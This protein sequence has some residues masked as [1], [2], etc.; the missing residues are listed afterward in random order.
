[1]SLRTRLITLLSSVLIVAFVSTSM[2]SYLVSKQRYR[3]GALDETLPLISNNILSE[4]QR[5]LMMPIHVSSL[6][7]NDTFLKDWVL[8]GEED[9]E[10]VTKY[11]KE[12]KSKYGFFKAVNDTYGHAVGDR[13]LKVL[14]ETIQGSLR[15]SDLLGRLGGE[16]FGVILPETDTEEGT[17]VAERIR[18][19]VRSRN[20]KTDRGDIHVTVSIGVSAAHAGDA[21]IEALLH[22]ADS[23]MYR[24]KANGRNRVEV[25]REG[26]TEAV[27]A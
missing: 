17:T 24:A 18:A 22:R 7:A 27:P 5:D 12:I 21:G 11:L 3:A 6:M 15:A 26:F 9:P 23:A 8:A 14:A 16:E 13:T 25:Q 1:M 4:V 20:L 19:A 10:R 2:I